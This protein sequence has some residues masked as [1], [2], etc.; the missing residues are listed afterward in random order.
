MS[1][2]W[3]FK[4]KFQ[5]KVFWIGDAHKYQRATGVTLSPPA[6]VRLE[7]RAFMA[8]TQAFLFLVVTS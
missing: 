4:L 2:I 3:N 5:E 7:R 6:S 8:Q 1:K